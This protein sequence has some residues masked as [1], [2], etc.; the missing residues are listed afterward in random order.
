MAGRGREQMEKLAR[1]IAEEVERSAGLGLN[2]AR[3]FL[4]SRI[5]EKVSEEA[6]RKTIKL[7]SGIT[8]YIA[9]TAATKGAP[10]R[11][12]SGRLRGSITSEMRGRYLAV[13]GVSA[14]APVTPKY[15]DGYPYPKHFE[16]VDPAHPSSGQHKFI[17]PTVNEQRSNLE[18]IV[19]GSIT[20]RIE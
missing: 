7:P 5:K 11:K 12:L 17:E 13:I 15:P 20:V 6:P 1:E 19:S 3:M 14:R 18:R 9:T 16:V 2:A 4:T 8:Y 10:P